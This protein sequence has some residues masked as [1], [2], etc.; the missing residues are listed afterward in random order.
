MPV[1]AYKGLTHTGKRTRGHLDAENARSARA[2]LRADG[3][4]PMELVQLDRGAA[5]EPSS[6][7]SYSY[8][9]H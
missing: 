8:Q 5:P 1:Y 6:R 2:R 3:V 9:H 4:T 7:S